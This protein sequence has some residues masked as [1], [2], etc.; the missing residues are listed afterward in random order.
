MGAEAL[1]LLPKQPGLAAQGVGGS[2][3]S[4]RCHDGSVA[5]WLLR[6]MAFGVGT[7]GKAGMLIR[8]A[9][10]PL[11]A[12]PS[13]RHEDAQPA[14]GAPSGGM[15]A[16]L[17]CSTNGCLPATAAVAMSAGGLPAVQ[18][19]MAACCGSCTPCPMCHGDDVM[20]SHVLPSNLMPSAS[21]PA[22]AGWQA[23]RPQASARVPVPRERER[24]YRGERL[25]QE[26]QPCAQRAAGGAPH[27]RCW[28]MSPRAR[29][30]AVHHPPF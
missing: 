25:S 10:A 21:H 28:H 9:P 22:C 2:W 3:P 19:C 20:H 29:P 6:H 15:L 5:A 1:W 4:K 27:E 14:P 13:T 16:G 18:P 30:S 7:L 8:P 17:R 26:T 23:G 24:R 12:S 11:P